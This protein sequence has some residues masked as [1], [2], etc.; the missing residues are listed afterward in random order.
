MIM[1]MMSNNLEPIIQ[2]FDTDNVWQNGKTL[3][4]CF[5]SYQ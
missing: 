3:I 2:S 1:K 4:V 5:T